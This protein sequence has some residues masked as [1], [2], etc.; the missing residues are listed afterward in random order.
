M[1]FQALAAPAVQN[2]KSRLIEKKRL[3]ICLGL[4]LI[5]ASS[6]LFLQTSRS[7]E[8]TESDQLLLELASMSLQLESLKSDLQ[9]QKV[10]AQEQ[11]I[12]TTSVR[13]SPPSRPVIP[14]AAGQA[15]QAVGSPALKPYIPR[16]AV[17]KAQLLTSIKTSVQGSV[18]VAETI[19]EFEMDSRRR[20]P[21]GTKLIGRATYDPT[22]KGVNVRF[23]TMT[24]PNGIQ[25]DDLDLLALSENAWPMIEGIVFDDTGVQM[26]TALGFG[27]L[28]GF[29]S[30]G[31]ERETTPFGSAPQASVKNQVL[32]GLSVASFQVAEQAME[33]MKSQA[34]EY[35]IVPAGMPIYV[36]FNRRWEL[37]QGGV[38]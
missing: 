17:F 9:S 4:V 6:F 1:S 25:Y 26:G 15:F 22:L 38:R 7:D 2:L 31:Q 11:S 36:L 34:F 5:A 30:G 32:S 10:R 28:S 23:E 37:P 33:R 24:S 3:F 27:F 14:V 13:Q 12:K 20:I 21:K 8:L 18:V 29:A 19:R 16:G 35:V